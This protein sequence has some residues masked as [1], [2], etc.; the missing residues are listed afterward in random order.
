MKLSSKGRYGLKAMCELAEHYG[1]G[2]L[3]LPYIAAQTE[4][5]E[6]YLEQLLS[7]L[8]K[9]NLVGAAR[10]ATG[11]YYLIKPPEQTSVGEILRCLENG[12]EIVDCISGE[13]CNKATCRTHNVW[14]R[15][16][17]EINRCLDGMS[18]KQLIDGE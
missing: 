10:G 15:L 14:A 3:S 5:S 9:D 17:K 18:L 4:L 6:K 13:C 8:K 7:A 11:G 12:L 16:Y 2:A 1:E